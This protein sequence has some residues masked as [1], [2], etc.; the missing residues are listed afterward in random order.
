[1][2]GVAA[3][4]QLRSVR[5]LG[6]PELL[7]VTLQAG[8]RPGEAR[9]AAVT[10]AGSTPATA[11]SIDAEGR[12]LTSGLWDEHVHF[13]QW[14]A[15]SARLDLGELA[16]ARRA[17]DRVAAAAADA[18]ARGATG[19]I[20]AMRARGDEWSGRMSRQLL[21]EAAGSIPVVLITA[22][23]HGAWLNSAALRRHGLP[24]TGDG[25]LV[26]DACFALLRELDSGSDGEL[27]GRVVDAG[28]AAAR[29]GVVGVVDFEMRWGISDWG[30]REASGFRS[31]RVETAIY[32]H[33]LERAIALGLRSGDP[34]G[35]AGLITVGPLK[36]ITD[37]SL[38]TATAWCCE[39]YPDGGHGRPLWPAVEL[40]ALLRRACAAG[41]DLAV[42]AIGD[43][44]NTEVLDAFERTG[45]TGRIEHA[46][47]LAD[48]DLERFARLGVTAS[49]QPAHLLDDRENAGRLWA[50]REH[51]AYRFASLHRAGGRLVLGSDAPV[52]P[53]DPWLAVQA[54]VL[55]GR[56][57][58][59]PWS[60]EERLPVEL[61]LAASMRGPL[62]P[63]PGDPADLVL[64]DADP[65]VIEPG[66][67]AGITV[68]ATLVGGV[69]THLAR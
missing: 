60:P 24:E 8:G 26:E 37:G 41:L 28:T 65:L 55:R 40:E 10:P 67:L 19:G 48:A 5:L 35:S 51:R 9:I 31:L 1:M 64:L 17:L 61:A 52:A 7:D 58:E 33:E 62:R 42:H 12:F 36:V 53:L 47:L 56:P 30:R 2:T 57:G 22:D 16:D 44:A 23:L 59:P 11:D 43:R 3:V 21:D 32:P 13:G 39:P 49:V 63:G 18:D 50:G 46:Q 14:A 54:A 27:D 68:A 45:T 6:R 66:S 4:T 20:V 38:G 69:P 34:I 29:R 25:H 15:Q